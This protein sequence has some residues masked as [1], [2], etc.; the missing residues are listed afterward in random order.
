MDFRSSIAIRNAL[1][2]ESGGEDVDM[3]DVLA[4]LTERF[5]IYGIQSWTVVDEKNQPV[6]VNRQTITELILSDIDLATE[7]G[8][9]ADGRYREATMLPLIRAGS[10]PSPSMPT[11]DSTSVATTRSTRRRTRASRSSITAIPTADTAMTSDSPD[12]DYS[13]SPKSA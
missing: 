11:S 12:G 2:L 4:I 7:I 8:D 3:A 10:K 5:V 9:V 6:P 1:A 13:S